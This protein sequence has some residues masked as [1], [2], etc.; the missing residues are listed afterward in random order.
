MTLSIIR[1]WI[2]PWFAWRQERRLARAIPG[3]PTDR[4]FAERRRAHK[5]IRDLVAK[6]RALIH[7]SMRAG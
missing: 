1:R 4:E 2:R 7:D 3:Y 5:P 6:R